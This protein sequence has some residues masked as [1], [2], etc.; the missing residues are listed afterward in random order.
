[1]ARP[2]PDD[3]D[4]PDFLRHS[5]GL[6]RLSALSL[7]LY[8]AVGPYVNIYLFGNEV[9]AS[10]LLPALGIVLMGIIIAIPR[11]FRVL[12][13]VFAAYTA[14]ILFITA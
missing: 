10:L 11:S 4:E 7:L 3:N 13:L 5:E 1:M 14:L 12:S 2:L 9:L 6:G 8:F